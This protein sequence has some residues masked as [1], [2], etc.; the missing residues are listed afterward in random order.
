[1]AA[2]LRF[3]FIVILFLPASSSAGEAARIRHILSVYSDEKGVGFQ[4]PE[5]IACNEKSLVVVGDTGN[6]RLYR[7]TFPE[8]TVKEGREIKIPQLSNPIRVQIN[9]RGEI[10]V[11]DGKQRRIARLDSEGAFKGYLTAEG[12]PSPS[13]FV[14]RSFKIGRDDRIY[15][16]DVFTGRVLVLDPEGKYQK[17][18]EFPKEYGFFSDLAVDAQGTVLMLDSVRAGIVSAAPNAT[19]FSPLGGSLKEYMKFPVGLTTDKKGTLYLTDGNGGAIGIVAQDGSFLGKHLSRGWNEGLLS[20]PTQ[21]CINENGEIFVA[22]RGNNR[23][24][25]FTL[26]K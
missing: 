10:F 12:L 15:I 8:R 11:L 24:Q 13:T 2:V 5:G 18:L 22:D 1:M 21:T 19:G 23:I 7:F 26:L 25:I 4:S 6:D 14:P 3:I 16:L 17:Q 20:S 9:S